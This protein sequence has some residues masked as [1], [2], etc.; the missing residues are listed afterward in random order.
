MLLPQNDVMLH[1]L[2]ARETEQQCRPY[3]GL[4]MIGEKCHRYLQYYHYMTFTKTI[5]KR[6]ERL[7]GFGHMMEPQMIKDLAD[8]GIIVQDTQHSMTGAGGHWKGHCDGIAVSLKEIAQ[9]FLAEFKTHSEKNFKLLVK[10]KVKAG[11]PKHHHQMNS[12]MGYLGLPFAFYL[13]YN[14]NDSDYHYETIQFDKE[15][16]EEDQRKE[17]EIIMSDVLLPRIGNGMSTWHECKM[18]DARKVCFQKEEVN[19][20][21]RSCEHVDVLPGGLWAC[22]LAEGRK[23]EPFLS[24]IHQKQMCENYTLGEMFK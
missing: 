5:N 17:S 2:N 10:L 4:S 3:L 6:I 8:I 12:Y 14:K 15:M 11:F 7:F 20:T 22:N 18:C 16:F 1:D 21:C 24:E 23:N 9:E 13:G 19:K